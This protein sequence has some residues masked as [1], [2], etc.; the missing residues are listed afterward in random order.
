VVTEVPEGSASVTDQPGIADEPATPRVA[1][2]RRTPEL[3]DVMIDRLAV[4]FAA[5]CPNG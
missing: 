4:G 1:G 2:R 5:A 3:I